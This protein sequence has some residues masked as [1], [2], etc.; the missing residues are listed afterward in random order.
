MRTRAICFLKSNG[1]AAL[2]NAQDGPHDEFYDH[3]QDHP[4]GGEV[5]NIPADSVAFSF[6][7]DSGEHGCKAFL[8]WEKVLRPT[9]AGPE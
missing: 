7:I 3:T 2:D 1:G 8:C 5:G 9:L 6:C 4:E